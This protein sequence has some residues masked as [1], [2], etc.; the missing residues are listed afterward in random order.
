[1]IGISA[2]PTRIAKAIPKKAERIE[3]S[4]IHSGRTTTAIT[5]ATIV[6]ATIAEC[7]FHTTGFCGR[8]L[9]SF[10]A[11]TKLPVNVTNP[12]T[13]ATAPTYISNSSEVCWIVRIATNALARPPKPLSNATA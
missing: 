7:A 8:S 5:V 1:M 11:A 6:T 10:P 2:P 3:I 4:H 12:T 13:R 9:C